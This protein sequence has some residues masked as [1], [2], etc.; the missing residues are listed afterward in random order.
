MEMSPIAV[1]VLAGLLEE[2]T[3]QQLLVARQWRVETALAPIMRERNIASLD[4]LAGLV[5]MSRDPRLLDEIVEALLNNETFFFRDL[6]AFELLMS[7]AETRFSDARSAEKRLRIWCAGCSTGQEAYSLAISFTERSSRWAGW[8]IEIVGTDVSHDAILRARQGLYSQFEIQRGLPIRQM[9]AWFGAEGDQWRARPELREKVSFHTQNLLQP[10][11]M[12]CFD[13]ILCRNVLL[14]FSSERRRTVFDRL[15]RAIAPDGMLMLGAGETV[16]GQTDQ[17]VSD[18][19]CRGLYRRAQ[20]C[21]Q[22]GQA[23]SAA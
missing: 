20:P 23:V 19:E 10:A 1:R 4:Q 11:A 9:L 21:I 18:A 22:E 13:I 2:R 7:Q 16:I 6:A 15:A 17:F 5:T 14:Y 8:N 12:G 3:G